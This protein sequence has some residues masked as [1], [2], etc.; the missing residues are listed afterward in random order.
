METERHRLAPLTVSLALTISCIF[1]DKYQQLYNSVPYN[2]HEMI[3]IRNSVEKRISSADYS[4]DCIVLSSKITAA[5]I[6]L[7][8]NKNDGGRGLPTNHFKFACTE[9]A[10]HTVCLF[11][12]FQ[13]HG[14]VIDNVLLSTTVPIPKG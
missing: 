10:I 1:A 8:P 3:D 4:E 5:I 12:G 13:V 6:R 7:K 14:S 11:S 2:T 9:L